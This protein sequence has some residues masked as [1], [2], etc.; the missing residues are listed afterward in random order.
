MSGLWAVLGLAIVGT[1]VYNFT[2][3]GGQGGSEVAGTGH[4]VVSVFNDL[5]GR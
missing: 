4:T 2:K 1:M 3:A 5:T